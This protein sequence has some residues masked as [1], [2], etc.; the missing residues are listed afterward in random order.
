MLVSVRVKHRRVAHHARFILR[1]LTRK[2][3]IE[4]FEA[5]TAGP[6]IKRAF[7][8]RLFGWRIVPLAPCAG[9][10]TVIFQYFRHGRRRLWDAAAETIKVIRQFANL[11][12]ADAGM[13]ASR[14]QRSAR[15]RTHRR[16]MAENDCRK[17]PASR[18][19][20]ASALL[21]LLP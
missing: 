6:E 13:I 20:R 12:V 11:T 18:C 14:Q 19:A 9:V 4:I 15:G 2:E 16:G 10:V 8:R 5:I 7:R 17:C 1:R 21:I 3:T